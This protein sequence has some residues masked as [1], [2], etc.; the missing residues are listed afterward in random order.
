MTQKNPSVS[1]WIWFLGLI[2]AGNRIQTSEIAE[3]G[4]ALGN[5]LRQ[6]SLI[7][8]EIDVSLYVGN[9]LWFTAVLCRNRGNALLQGGGKDFAIRIY[10]AAADEGGATYHQMGKPINMV[11]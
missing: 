6:E 10:A 1:R 11:S 3:I 8:A 7:I 2:D 9:Q 5:N 4:Q